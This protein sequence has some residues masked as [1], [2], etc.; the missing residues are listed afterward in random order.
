LREA[1]WISNT[2][3]NIAPTKNSDSHYEISLYELPPG[4]QLLVRVGSVCVCVCVCVCVSCS[5]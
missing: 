3:Y 1:V 5:R 2:N 4:K